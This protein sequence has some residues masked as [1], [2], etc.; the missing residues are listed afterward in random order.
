[1]YK[2]HTRDSLLQ[3]IYTTITNQKTQS[4]KQFELH[5]RVLQKTDMYTNQN[6]YVSFGYFRP[7]RVILKTGVTKLGNSVSL[8]Y[9]HQS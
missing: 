4:R 1:M 7:G 9:S 8:R 2:I 6:P 5:D 3:S